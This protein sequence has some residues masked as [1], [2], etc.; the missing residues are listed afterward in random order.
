MMEYIQPKVNNM[1]FNSAA[2]VEY[3]GPP[4][5]NRPYQDRFKGE[6]LPQSRAADS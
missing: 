1:D 2:A 5:V 6:P 3:L 4:A